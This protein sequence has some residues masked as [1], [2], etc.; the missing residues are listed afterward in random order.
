[1]VRLAA[2]GGRLSSLV[3]LL[4][5][6]SRRWRE[7]EE[8]E[9]EVTPFWA[10][11]ASDAGGAEAGVDKDEQ[12]LPHGFELA[13]SLKDNG[14]DSFAKGAVEEAMS[15][16]V[17]ALDALHAPPPEG[18]QAVDNHRGTV[19]ALSSAGGGTECSEGCSSATAQSGAA[20]AS[21]AALAAAAAAGGL[22]GNPTAALGSLLQAAAAAAA[23]GGIGDRQEDPRVVDL[24]VTLY[25]NL[26]LGHMKKR[27]WRQAL[28]FCEEA[29]HDQPKSQKALYRKADCLGELG[30]WTEAEEVL[31][32][33]EVLGEEASKLA[34]HKRENW[35]KRWKA[36]DDKQ[37]K[38]WSTALSKQKEKVEPPE[39]AKE[40]PAPKLLAKPKPMVTPA[41]APPKLVPTCVFDLRRK[42]VQW[43]ENED[44]DDRVWKDGLGHSP[45]TGYYRQAMPLTL[46]AASA[47]AD[48]DFESQLTL[49]VILDGN[50]APFAE[51]HDWGL[52]LRRCPQMKA[53]M[54][55][56]I[57]L[58]RIGEKPPPGAAA[59][60]Y[61]T[62]LRPVEEARIGDRVAHSARFLG[63][64]KEFREHCLELPGIVAPRIALWADAP[65]YGAGDHDLAVRV[66]A[67]SMLAT[68][69]VP[70]V[71]TQ[72]SEISEQG[73]PT[74]G[75]WLADSARL[76][77]AI[78][79]LGLGA[80]PVQGWH[81]NRFVIPLDQT[82][83]G[84]LA[85]HALVGLVRPKGPKATSATGASVRK[86]LHDHQVEVVASRRVPGLGP[87]TP[88]DHAAL[89][90]QYEV[91]CEQLR[92]SGRPVGPDVP[93]QERRRQVM[94]FHQFCRAGPCPF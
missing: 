58:G 38:M 30:S 68:Q 94:E 84:I 9:G 64:Y 79:E 28:G 83:K 82:E 49:H 63:T 46:L 72:E 29:L 14:N 52:L 42:G 2:V 22:G 20:V 23:A 90:A 80:K 37:K 17:Q 55:V 73:G 16:W 10:A 75:P 27:Q 18:E 87:P 40:P 41:W 3:R 11:R 91:F 4:G 12:P 7:E 69:G 85:A 33:L 21:A 25:S 61:G 81:W 67:L 77:L 36:A 43:V 86:A 47:L 88:A 74:G 31:A 76:S 15:I 60:P 66:E 51:P 57:D 45:V 59:M 54:V 65:L 34:V 93:E 35:R 5:T 78:L 92:R 39:P 56:Y 19:R 53:L 6:C 48:M 50:C 89:R 26:A 70:I 24:R 32:K 44:F 13:N 71:V 8:E 62:L 1:M